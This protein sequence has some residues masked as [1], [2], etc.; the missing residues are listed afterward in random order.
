MNDVP[1]PQ[2]GPDAPKPM[3]QESETNA[4]DSGTPKAEV[5]EVEAPEKETA[6]I[7][8]GEGPTVEV[9]EEVEPKIVGPHLT[10]TPKPHSMRGIKIGKVVV[11]IC[12][13][14][15]GEPLSRAMTILQNI[16][17]QRPCTRLA[18]QTIRTF[19]IRRKEPISCMVTLRGER[20]EEFL[21]KGLAAVGNRIN[22]RSFDRQGN[23]AFG[24]SEHIDIPGQRYDPSLGI[25]GMDVMATVERPGYRVARRRRGRSRVGRS[26][27]VTRDEAIEFIKRSFGVEVG[28]P[29]E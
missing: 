19:G 18:K 17:G 11:N 23:F 29:S 25:T 20:A 2:D 15:S 27:R 13:G 6:I 28:L 22:P 3:T 7:S 5:E 16:T 10:E 9:Q 8:A 26:H 14:Q 12:T 21:R 4:E 1:P 24:I